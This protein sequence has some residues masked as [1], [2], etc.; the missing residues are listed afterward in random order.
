MYMKML[1][2]AIISKTENVTYCNIELITIIVSEL[3]RET[4]MEWSIYLNYG[5]NITN[6]IFE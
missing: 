3:N 1:P 4:K 6:N 5:N 2:C